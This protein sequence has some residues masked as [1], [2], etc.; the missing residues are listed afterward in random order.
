MKREAGTTTT[1]TRRP[2]DRRAG[3]AK[4]FESRPR[5]LELD[6]PEFVPGRN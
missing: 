1:S 3:T 2:P 6:V 5:D 4:E